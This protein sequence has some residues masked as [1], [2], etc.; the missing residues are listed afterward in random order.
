MTTQVTSLSSNGKKQ[1]WIPRETYLRA[2]SLVLWLETHNNA[3]AISLGIVFSEAL[4]LL[5][6][7]RYPEVNSR[8]AGPAD[9][10]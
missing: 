5:I 9:D 6:K 1:V 8:I 3:K 10:E 7:E 2:K 4:N